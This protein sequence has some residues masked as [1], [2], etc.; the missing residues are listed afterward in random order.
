MTMNNPI[1]LYIHIPFCKRKCP[2][3]DFY[4]VGYDDS[5]AELYA[6]AVVRNIRHYG[7]CFDTVYFG[8]GTPILLHKHIGEILRAAD[9]APDAEITAECNPCFINDK[10]LYSLL[11]GGVNRLSV[12][13]Q[14]LD[15]RELR[16]LGRLHDA[17]TAEEAV[18]S[19]RAAGFENISADLM[20]AVPQQTVQSLDRTLDRLCSLP[21]D[22]VSAYMLKIE[23]DTP[24]G[25]NT[26]AVPDEDSTADMYLHAVRRLA[27]SGFSQYEISNF[28]KR[29]CECAHNL[30]YWR[31]EEY[32]GIGPA[33]HS[34][35]G[36]RRFEVARDIDGFIAS[37][38]QTELTNDNAPDEYE[39]RVMLGLRLSEGIP[40][41]LY[42]PLSG[43]LKY[44]PKQYYRLENGRLSLT[45]EGFL[46][47]N[48][49]ISLLLSRME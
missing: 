34:F 4:S 10:T 12:G 25:R 1:G 21:I 24:F 20:L 7:G 42:S 2:Y 11:S 45:A 28:A 39:E 43:G 23:P 17:D 40:E 13:V 33:A 27:E 3:C 15:D 22:H 6:Q 9:V 8:G 30:K 32:L 47:S 16:A 29:G 14:S 41:E 5:L 46:V 49:I 48:E 31:R 37:P 19:A 35:Y 26:P 36:G 18:L 38:V 44:I